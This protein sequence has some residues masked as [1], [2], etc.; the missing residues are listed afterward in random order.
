MSAI[1]NMKG[2]II[3][4]GKIIYQEQIESGLYLIVILM[5][6]PFHAAHRNSSQL[7]CEAFI[8]NGN[9]HVWGNGV[10]S[11]EDAIIIEESDNGKFSQLREVKTKEGHKVW[12]Q[13][14]QYDEF[15]REKDGKKVIVKTRKL[16]WLVEIP[17]LA[18]LKYCN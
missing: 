9:K 12:Q 17:K 13:D 15:E 11:M 3:K 4:D 10:I 18:L 16:Q 14:Y 8:S 6:E 7:I 2:H 1:N 5:Y